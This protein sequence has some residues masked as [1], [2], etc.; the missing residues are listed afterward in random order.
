MGSHDTAKFR[1]VNVD[2]MRRIQD[3][4][5]NMTVP[6]WVES[7]P[8][9]FG[10]AMIGTLKAGEWR[11][12]A[13][14]YLPIALII[15]WSETTDHPDVAFAQ[16]LCCI[17]DHTLLLVSAIRLACRRL[18]SQTVSK[19]YLGYMT[20]Y[21]R[22][23]EALHPDARCTLNLHASIHIAGFIEKFG[24]V[25]SWWTFPF[26]R[27]IG[28]LQNINTNHHTFG[29][30]KLINVHHVSLPQLQGKWKAPLLSPFLK[31]PG[32]DTGWLA[33]NALWHC[34]NAEFCSTSISVMNFPALGVMMMTGTSKANLLS[35]Q[36]AYKRQQREEWESCVQ[37]LSTKADYLRQVH[38][39]KEIAWYC[40]V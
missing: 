11:T 35:F 17:L 3:V 21:M 15:L 16:Y 18:M 40:L 26:E 23:L 6:A 1:H 30:L 4:I 14:V 10:E 31:D 9:N 22:E 39:T 28:Q 20:Q 25:H 37:E 5:K 2:V 13:T 38:A 34:K 33:Q 12:L 24:P 32:F 27:L 7:V 8:E 36:S 29:A 19:R